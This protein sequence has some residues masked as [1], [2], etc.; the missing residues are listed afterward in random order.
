MRDV[1]VIRA[2]VLGLVLVVLGAVA[3]SAQAAPV[4]SDPENGSSR[5]TAPLTTTLTFDG[6]V[7]TRG[8]SY[9]VTTGHEGNQ[10]GPPRQRSFLHRNGSHV[11]WG[12]LAAVVAIGLLLAPLRRRRDDADRT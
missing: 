9:D 12:I 4:G 1:I 11:I 6:N 5:P 8:L 10:V 7:A 3:A 2:I